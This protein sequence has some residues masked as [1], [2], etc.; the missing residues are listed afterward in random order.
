MA[1]FAFGK[2]EIAAYQFSTLPTHDQLGQLQTEGALNFLPYSNSYQA[3]ILRPCAEEQNA[4]IAKFTPEKNRLALAR[5]CTKLAKKILAQSPMNPWA[6]LALANAALTLKDYIRVNDCLTQ[7]YK[8]APNEG[9][10]AAHRVKLAM[11]LE[12]NLSVPTKKV[13]AIDIALLAQWNQTRP[14]LAH[15]Y[16]DMNAQN[17]LIISIVNKQPTAQKRAFLEAVKAMSS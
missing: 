5:S 11:A 14:F 8:S 13:L 6:H 17:E 4:T 16:L 12:L 10:I 1:S 7:A 15:L 2:A 3:A 9:I